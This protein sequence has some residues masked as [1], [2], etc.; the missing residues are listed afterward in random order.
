MNKSLFVTLTVMITLTGIT[1]QAWSQQQ[2]MT[3]A[4]S[5][6][7]LVDM[8]YIFKNYDK[9]KNLRED[10][11]TE[12]K[13]SEEKAKGMALQ[14]QNL[15]K[16]LESPQIKEGGPAYVQK[17]KELI[18]LRSEFEAYR[19]NAQREFVKKESEIYK[20]V[21]LEVTDM[22]AAYAKHKNFTMVLRFD[23]T[24]LDKANG[25]PKVILSKMN[26]Q[27]VYFQNSNDI[28]QDVLKYLKQR[29]QGQTATRPTRRKTN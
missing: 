12:F 29:Y 8:A 18:Q 11:N 14:I 5:R 20:T 13:A 16:Q 3:P 1:I 10:L 17:E 21:Y 23:S 2:R 24:L 4:A 15:T 9:F 28:T 22:V 26:Q 6:I 7:A 25:D 19:K 27:V